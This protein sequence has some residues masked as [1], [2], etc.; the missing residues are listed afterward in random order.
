M[1]SCLRDADMNELVKLSYLHV[2][3][4]GGWQI[5]TQRYYRVH[6]RKCL[7]LFK[8]EDAHRVC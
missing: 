4:D 3:S 7:K 5:F 1:L 8:C 6:T 2:L